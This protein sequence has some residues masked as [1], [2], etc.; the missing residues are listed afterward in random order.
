MKTHLLLCAATAAWGLAASGCASRHDGRTVNTRQPGPAIG[1]AAG[2]AVGAVAG[3]VTGAVVGAGEGF[4]GA[5]ASAFDNDR[6]IVRTWRTETTSDGRTIR[7]PVEI[8]VDRD[9]RPIGSSGASSSGSNQSPTG[10]R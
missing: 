10:P 6:R 8:E 3:N 9:G 1:T 7:V 4:V 2:T 5:S